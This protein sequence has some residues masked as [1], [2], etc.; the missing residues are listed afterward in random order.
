MGL[1]MMIKLVFVWERQ[2]EMTWKAYLVQ[3]IQ[4]YLSIRESEMTLAIRL[5]IMKPFVVKLHPNH[6]IILLCLSSP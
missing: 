2:G 6:Q 1:R 4:H 5:L 3:I